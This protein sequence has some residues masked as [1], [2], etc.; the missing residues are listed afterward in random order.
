GNNSS[1]NS[2]S[3]SFASGVTISMGKLQPK[4]LNDLILSS[5]NQEYFSPPI[6]GIIR[7]WYRKFPMNNDE[8]DLKCWLMYSHTSV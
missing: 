8:D 6:N 4:D 7:P 3:Y 2:N 5:D 1:Q